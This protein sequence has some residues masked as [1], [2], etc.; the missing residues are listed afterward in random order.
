MQQKKQDLA[1]TRAN[2]P[3]SAVRVSSVSANSNHTLA[4]SEDGAVYSF[5]YMVRLVSW[6]TATRSTS[7]RRGSSRGCVTSERA[8]WQR[9]PH[10]AWCWARAAPSTLFGYGVDDVGGLGTATMTAS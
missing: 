4:L 8:R 3:T 9:E 2:T 1:N 7:A 5:G 6:A 10:T